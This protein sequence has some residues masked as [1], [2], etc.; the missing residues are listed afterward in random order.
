MSKSQSSSPS[1]QEARRKCRGSATVRASTLFYSE[2]LDVYWWCLCPITGSTCF[3]LADRSSADV[4]PSPLGGAFLCMEVM[5]PMSCSRMQNSSS[6]QLLSSICLMVRRVR[7]CGRTESFLLTQ[8]KVE[9]FSLNTQRYHEN[10]S[11]CLM[12]RN[13]RES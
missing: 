8:Y 12:L 1:D 3:P 10:H 7:E 4:L 2:F 5:S 11:V 9:D 13:F 6:A